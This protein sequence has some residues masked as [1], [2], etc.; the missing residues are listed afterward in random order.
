MPAACF[1][2]TPSSLQRTPNTCQAMATRSSTALK[3]L[4]NCRPSDIIKPCPRAICW[5]TGR[6]T[7]GLHKCAPKRSLSTE[8]SPSEGPRTAVKALASFRS[9]VSRP[10]RST[11]PRPTPTSSHAARKRIQERELRAGVHGSFRHLP[12]QG[13]SR[14]ALYGRCRHHTAHPRRRVR[15]GGRTDGLRQVHA[16]EHRRRAA[17]SLKR[18]R[19]GVRP[20]AAGHQP[21][22]RL[23][24]PDR[25]A[26]ALAQLHRQRRMVGLQ[27][28][29]CR[30]QMPVAAPRGR[31]GWGWAD[32]RTAIAPAFAHGS[33]TALARCWRWTRN[34]IR[35][36]ALH[37][38][39]IQNRQ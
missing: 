10:T 26:A 23:H 36:R 29:A 7:C 25:G 31:S 33:C 1:Y 19:A 35:G 9:R 17:G 28:Q 27:Y 21:P 4:Q 22:G 24:V 30:M 32:S 13:R 34:I 38:L 14:A 15:F 16:A 11:C 6:F 2:P 20:A 5:V 39:E 37:A 3:W 8:L 18:Q 12:L